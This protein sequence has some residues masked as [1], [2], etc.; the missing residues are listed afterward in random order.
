V[1][2]NKDLIPDTAHHRLSLLIDERGFDAVIFSPLEDNSLI[3]ERVDF[4]LSP[5]HPLA[6]LE[7]A[8]YDNPLL[9]ADFESTVILIDTPRFLVI[10]R[11]EA[12]RADDM[13]R[14]LYPSPADEPS[15][16]LDDDFETVVSDLPE[17]DAVIAMAAGRKLVSFFKRSFNLPVI[18][19]RLTPLV[20]Y[21]SHR[22]RF[23]NSGKLHLHL[24]RDGAD[25]IAFNGASLL[26]ANSF[27]CSA[28]D[29]AAFFALSAADML[30]FDTDTDRMLISG[31]LSQ[32]ELLM[33]RLRKYI[34][35]VMP[36]IFPSEMFRVGKAALSAPLELITIPLS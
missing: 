18:A 3:H 2:L 34:P 35:M 17:A 30:G 4:A 13:L 24:R 23:G 15:L 5:K 19:H 22:T 12:G 10:P 25:I 21:F 8:V 32:R 14:A 11:A 9:L 36:V 20:R 28:A 7:D 16:M 27:A 1:P 26:M 6:A 31:A 33:S 29:D